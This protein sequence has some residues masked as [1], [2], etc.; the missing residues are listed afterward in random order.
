MVHGEGEVV[1]SSLL[2]KMLEKEDYSTI[3]GIS[4]ID[5]NGNTKSI[6]LD[7]D[8]G[9]QSIWVFQNMNITLEI[10]TGYGALFNIFEF[11]K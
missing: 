7:S 3:N 5:G 10:G 6:D 1:L 4:Y 8:E 9:R 2:L 11:L